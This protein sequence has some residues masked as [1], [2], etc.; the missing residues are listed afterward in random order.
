MT[1]GPLGLAALGDPERLNPAMVSRVV[2]RLHAMNLII[3]QPNPSDL[4]SASVTATETGTSTYKLIQRQQTAVLSR[5]LKL[6]EN[7][8]E[9]ALADAVP[10]L[11]ELA[12][13]LQGTA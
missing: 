2:G 10:A 8:C 1:R 13:A 11:E 3:R 7:S 12:G 4:R 5:C 6:L 9:S